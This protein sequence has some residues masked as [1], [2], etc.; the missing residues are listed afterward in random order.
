[1]AVLLYYP[2]VVPPVEIVHQ[3]LLYWDGLSSVVPRDPE[4][5]QAAVSAELLELQQRELYAPLV[6]DDRPG[7]SDDSGY[8]PVM[9]EWGASS[10]LVRELERMASR[11]QPPRP[12]SPPDSFIYWS[13][14]NDRLIRRL[15]QLGLA[16]PQLQPFPGVAVAQEV[17]QTVIGTIVRSLALSPPDGGAAEQR[18]YFPCTDREDAHR[19]AHQPLGQARSL[20]W[21]V[22]I[23]RLLPLPVPGTPT[24]EVLAFRERYTDERVRLMRAVHRLLGDLRRD[25]EHPA[26]VLAQ[27]RRELTEAVEDFQAAAKGSRMVWINRSVTAAV[28]LGAAAA[29]SLLV[30]DLGWVLGTVGAYALNVATRETR[31]VTNAAQRHDFSYLHRVRTQLA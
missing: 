19:L 1:M 10:V 3:A 28:A 27:L 12:A 13:K 16:E 18:A 23:G 8:A 4:V 29:G 31:P 17:Q 26:D 11:P 2:L 24:G 25:Y 15:I 7:Y 21:E 14:V 30:P 9:R 6:Y 5:F 22:E 20:S